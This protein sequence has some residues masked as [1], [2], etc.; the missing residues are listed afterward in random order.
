MRLSRP[1]HALPGDDSSA[2]GPMVTEAID[3]AID[4]ATAG[5]AAGI[6]TNPIQK[7]SCTTPAS[8]RPDTLNTWESVPAWTRPVMLLASPN[9]KVVPVTIHLSLK[10]AIG[11]LTTEEIAHAGNYYQSLKLIMASSILE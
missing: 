10:D 2:D 5:E 1:V 9:L 11:V 4:A 6:T 3:R 7:A 8:L